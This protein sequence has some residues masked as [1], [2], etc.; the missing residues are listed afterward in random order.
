MPVVVPAASNGILSWIPLGWGLIIALIVAFNAFLAALK[1]VLDSIP[2]ANKAG[3]IVGTLINAL[4]KFID[5]VGGNV[6]HK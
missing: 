3:G 2:A 4:S 1:K 6:E 5:L